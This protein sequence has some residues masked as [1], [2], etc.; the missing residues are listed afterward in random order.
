[1]A[2]PA[3]AVRDVGGDRLIGNHRLGHHR[4]GTRDQ[5]HECHQQKQR[6]EFLEQL[7]RRVRRQQ[8]HHAP[9]EHR[10]HG[11]EQGDHETGGKQRN[12]QAPRLARIM[13]IEREQACRRLGALR[14][15]RGF[16]LPLEKSEHGALNNMA[17]TG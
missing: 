10:D 14:R 4:G 2:L 8:G 12:E 15:L 17:E 9:D 11:V 6:P 16:Q 13:P 3:D 7:V 5:Q 1:M